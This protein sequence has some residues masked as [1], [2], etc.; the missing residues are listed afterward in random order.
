M[1]ISNL[2]C[3]NDKTLSRDTKKTGANIFCLHRV[4]YI[5]MA[6]AFALI[7]L[8]FILMAGPSCTMNEFNPDVFSF[9]R[10]VLAP[11]LS[12]LGYLLMVV[13][14]MRNENENVNENQ[15]ENEKPLTPNR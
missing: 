5:I 12:F 4:N 15:N 2:F 11:T 3:P 14:I 6:I 13:G 1:N 7:L 9:R 8:G 10:S